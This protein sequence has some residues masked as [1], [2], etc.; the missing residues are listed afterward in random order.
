MNPTTRHDQG[1]WSCAVP[2]EATGANADEVA[3]DG[4]FVVG[5]LLGKR[6]H[7]RMREAK[8]L[9]RWAGFTQSEDS[10]EPAANIDADSIA[11]FERAHKPTSHVKAR[12][13][14][15]TSHV[16]ARRVKPTSHVKARSV[17]APAV[18]LTAVPQQRECNMCFEILELDE[19]WAITP[20]YHA[21]TCLQCIEKICSQGP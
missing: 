8:Y 11:A 9:V 16:K 10:W 19:V 1:P 4:C 17:M 6:K 20:C 15:P 13:V 3:G 2:E 18:A 12:R 14:K 7:G 21:R 5:A